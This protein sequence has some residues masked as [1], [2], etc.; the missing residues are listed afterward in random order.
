MTLGRLFAAALA[1]LLA[2]PLGVLGFADA[3]SRAAILVASEQ[4]RDDVGKRVAAGVGAAGSGAERAARTGRVRGATVATGLGAPAEARASGDRR[5]VGDAAEEIQ[6]PESGIR[7][8]RPTTLAQGHD[9]CRFQ[10][11]AS[12]KVG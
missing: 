4:A 6:R 9:A 12:D 2:V 10:F 11:H 8:E 5:R 1:G 7:F 3:Q